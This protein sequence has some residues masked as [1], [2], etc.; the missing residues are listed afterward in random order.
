MTDQQ[1][2]K[3]PGSLKL[4]ARYAPVGCSALALGSFVIN[5]EWGKFI[6]TIPPTILTTIWVAYSKAFLNELTE[7]YREE[8]KKGANRFKRFTD[9]LNEAIS[10]TLDRTD[11]KYLKCQSYPCQDFQ[12]E[13][14]TQ[15]FIPQLEEV[16]VPV[17]FDATGEINY[18]DFLSSPRNNPN[19]SE[20][21]LNV[22]KIWD[23]LKNGQK[24][25]TYRR[26]LIKSQGGYGKTTLLRHITYLYTQKRQPKNAPKLLPILLRLRKWQEKIYQENS[27]DLSTLIEKYHLPSLPEGNSLKIPSNWAKNNLKNG[28]LLILW[29]GFD[30]VKP[31]WRESV[32][33]WLGQQMSQYPNSFFILT[34]RPKGYNEGYSSEHKPLATLFIKPFNRQQIKDLVERW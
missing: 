28:N 5:S 9:N 13:G 15:S 32:S 31:E 33:Q 2:S 23:L 7:I 21:E 1:P 11:E 14:L 10:R 3:I 8:G 19:L 26:L 12:I 6:I 25:G 30:E 20:A 22:I 24:N 16:F 4:I 27:L 34:S 18:R 29:D 17:A